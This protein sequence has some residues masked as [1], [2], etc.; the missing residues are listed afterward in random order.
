MLLI[1][2][3]FFIIAGFF[4]VLNRPAA[5]TAGKEQEEFL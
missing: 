5:L 4:A 1:P 2:V 3:I